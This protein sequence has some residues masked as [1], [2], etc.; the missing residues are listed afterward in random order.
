M[1]F[2]KC[3]FSHPQI[4]RGKVHGAVDVSLAVMS[5]N[6][7]SKRIDLDAGDSLYHVKVC[8]CMT[9]NVIV[10]VFD[11]VNHTLAHVV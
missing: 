11:I 9:K 3:I 8:I 4:V 1:F 5:V 10:V 2:C 7:K 6:R